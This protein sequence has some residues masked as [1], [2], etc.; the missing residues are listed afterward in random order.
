LAANLRSP[1]NTGRLLAQLEPLT[2][3]DTSWQSGAEQKHDADSD[4]RG[5]MVAADCAIYLELKTDARVHPVQLY[6]SHGL[7]SSF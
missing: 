2:D 4:H 6:Q 3:E 5:K 1:T 7:I